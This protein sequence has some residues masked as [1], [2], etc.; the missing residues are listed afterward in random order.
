MPSE[1]RNRPELERCYSLGRQKHPFRFL[2][3]N[4]GNSSA[5]VWGEMRC[6]HEPYPYG[7]AGFPTPH[8]D[9]EFWVTLAW[10]LDDNE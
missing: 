6:C 3:E 9:L 2:K 4:A 8:F 10:V 1:E 5:E 7:T